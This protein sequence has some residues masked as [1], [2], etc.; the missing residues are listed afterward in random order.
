MT[1]GKFSKF[2]DAGNKLAKE[3]LDK[4][5][6]KTEATVKGEVKEDGTIAVKSIDP[7]S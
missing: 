2:D 6:A 5:D 3:Y 4:K 7:Q 1:D